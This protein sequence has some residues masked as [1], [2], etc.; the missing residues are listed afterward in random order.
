MSEDFPSHQVSRDDGEIILTEE[1][2]NCREIWKEFLID[3]ICLSCRKLQGVFMNLPCV[4][5]SVFRT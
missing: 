3:L 4:G 5:Q 1:G 2:W